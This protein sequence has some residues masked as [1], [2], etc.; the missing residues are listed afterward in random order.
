VVS[1]EKL[2]RTAGWS[3]RY[4]SRETFEITM[5]THGKLPLAESPAAESPAADSPAADPPYVTF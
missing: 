5:R 2:K 1:N 3:P 4:T